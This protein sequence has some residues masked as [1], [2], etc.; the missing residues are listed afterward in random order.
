ME[1][2][3]DENGNQSYLSRF[4][5]EAKID[6]LLAR[7]TMAYPTFSGCIRFAIRRTK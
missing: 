5:A 1:G 3:N 7:E 2:D 6:T 4:L